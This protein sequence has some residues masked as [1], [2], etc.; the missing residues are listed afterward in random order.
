[1]TFIFVS[2]NTSAT[3]R[4]SAK[5]K[6][7]A[8]SQLCTVMDENHNDFRLDSVESVNDGFMTLEEFEGTQSMD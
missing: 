4:V 8:Y 7:E 3:F 1:M 6:E 2:K 5:T